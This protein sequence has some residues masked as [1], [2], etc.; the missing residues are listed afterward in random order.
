MRK[1]NAR[2]IA[3]LA[4][5]TALSM[6][7]SYVETLLPFTGFLPGFKV[8]LG[9]LVTV[10]LLYRFRAVE[11]FAVTLIRVILLGILFGNAYGMAFSFAGFLLSFI[12]MA[13]LRKTGKFKTV[14]V[15]VAG[16]VL[17]NL[18]QIGVACALLGVKEIAYYAAP[19]TVIGAVSGALIGVVAAILVKRIPISF[20][21]PEEKE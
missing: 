18:A 8:G 20:D 19:L 21:G 12:V 11:A 13:V 10:F 7:L 15:S 2:R 3:F 5:F 17:H 9:N 16:G 14:T 6:I 4:L 1:M